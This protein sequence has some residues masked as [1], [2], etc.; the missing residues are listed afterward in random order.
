MLNVT[1]FTKKDCKLCEEVK[2]DLEA[3]RDQF[4]H[5]LVEVDIETDS[6]LMEKYKNII[7]VLE[8]GP[9]KIQAPIS[10]QKLKNDSWG[11]VRP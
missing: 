3:L 9:Y 11:G 1:L 6:A 4:P 7:P 10:R 5:R 2:A 8:V